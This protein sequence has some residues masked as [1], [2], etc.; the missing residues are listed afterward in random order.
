MSKFDQE[1][2][3]SKAHQQTSSQ[4]ML[5]DVEATKSYVMK[6]FRIKEEDK[7]F[8]KLITN[9]PVVTIWIKLLLLVINFILPGSLTRFWN[10]Y[11]ELLI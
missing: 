5:F 3:P 8:W 2:P 6:S 10:N 4:Q 11:N 1:F 9:F 7:D